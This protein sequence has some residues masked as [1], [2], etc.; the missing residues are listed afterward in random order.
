MTGDTSPSTP[1]VNMEKNGRVPDNVDYGGSWRATHIYRCQV[2]GTGTN[3]WVFG[4]YPGRGPRLP[5]P[6]EDTSEHRELEELHRRRQELQKGTQ[7]Y[8][9]ST[10]ADAAT[11]TSSKVA[12]RVRTELETVEEAIE[13][14]QAELAG[15]Y[16]NVHAADLE[17]P[18]V[19]FNDV[20]EHRDTGLSGGV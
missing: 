2:C 5:C 6:A 13:R 3:R 1:T 8:A 10:S 19:P 17:L 16:H 15:E 18:T 7:L 20:Q 12:Q 14:R 9:D 11:V 4:G